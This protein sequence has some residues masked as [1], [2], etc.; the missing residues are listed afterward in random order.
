MWAGSTLDRRSLDE[1]DVLSGGVERLNLASPGFLAKAEGA[2]TQVTPILVTSPQ[3]MQI[4]A[5]KFGMMPDPVGLLRAYK[6][7]G[8]A[9]MLAARVAGDGQQRLP[10]G[11]AQARQERRRQGQGRR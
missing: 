9:L 7:E 5:E 10:R 2:T 4:A 8:K 11:R 1:K 6:P 3:A